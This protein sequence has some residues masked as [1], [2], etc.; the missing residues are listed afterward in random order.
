[1]RACHTTGDSGKERRE[2]GVAD[3]GNNST[4]IWR[5]GRV[6]CE[7]QNMQRR[8]SLKFKRTRKLAAIVAA[9]LVCVCIFPAGACADGSYEMV[10]SLMAIEI[11]DGEGAPTPLDSTRFVQETENDTTVI[12]S[13]PDLYIGISGRNSRNVYESQYYSLSE[14]E[15]LAYMY[16]LCGLFEQI[17]SSRTTANEFYM[18]IVTEEDKDP[19]VIDTA[20][21]AQKIADLIA[22]AIK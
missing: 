7:K 11:I 20:A 18:G 5:T 22:D 19:T 21:K 13:F 4:F 6:C 1:M 3:P 2:K 15:M 9:V 10:K 17:D 16:L 12:I 14:K 8:S